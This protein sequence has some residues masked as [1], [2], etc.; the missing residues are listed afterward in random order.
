MF[1]TKNY[2]INVKQINHIWIFW[3]YYNNHTKGRKINIEEFNG[4]NIKVLSI[5]NNEKTPSLVFYCKNSKYKFKC[6][7]T[8]IQGDAIDFIINLYKKPYITCCNLILKDYNSRKEII[9]YNSE[10]TEDNFKILNY[11]ISNFNNYDKDFWT[12]YC[13]NTKIL[14]KYNVKPMSSIVYS[15]KSKVVE[16]SLI[17]TY[18]Y[19]TKFEEL[20]KIYQPLNKNCKFLI[21]N[22]KVIQGEDQLEGFNY[23][24]I[25]SSL[26]DIMGI[27]TI[28]NINLDIIAPNSE[29]TLLNSNKIIEYK[30]KY[31]KIL[32]LMDNDKVGKTAALK[33]KNLYNID[34]IFLKEKDP[35]D[36]IKK[37]GFKYFVHSIIPKINNK[38]NVEI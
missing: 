1:T 31:E 24:L 12:P 15:K 5:F 23:L 21:L 33:Y 28:S 19:F 35:T 22:N 36:T 6:F 27:K 25:T 10:P 4:G 9:T 3:H 2:E 14:R 38:I 17:K 16:K 30:K 37:L 32:T 34:Y 20:Y 8:G 7:S 26:K 13:I 18:G 11:K 29:N